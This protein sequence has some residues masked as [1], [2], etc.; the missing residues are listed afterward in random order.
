MECT[1]LPYSEGINKKLQFL[2]HEILQENLDCRMIVLFG[3]YARGEYNALSDFDFLVIT[4]KEVPRS[5]RGWLH[6]IF[7]ENNA[8]LVF[9]TEE[10]FYNSECFFVQQVK[11]DGVLLWRA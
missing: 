9:Y 2:V 3:S 10:V 4:E 8:D 11:K 1:A 5:V 7:D 6:S